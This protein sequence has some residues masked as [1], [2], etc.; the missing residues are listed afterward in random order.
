MAG[1]AWLSTWAFGADRDESVTISLACGGTFF[2]WSLLCVLILTSWETSARAAKGK[3]REV[4]YL[5]ERRK[6]ANK[7]EVTG[8]LQLAVDGEELQGS[9]ELSQDA[10]SLSIAD[11][12]SRR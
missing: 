4:T 1:L 8:A 11:D 2:V 3:L 7:Q 6:I 10:G 9:L 5:R 12:D